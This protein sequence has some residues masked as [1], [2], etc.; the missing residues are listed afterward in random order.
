MRLNGPS[1][2]NYNS[3]PAPE[4]LKG[5]HWG[6]SLASRRLGSTTACSNSCAPGI[7]AV[8]R[9][10][11]TSTAFAASSCFKKEGVCALA[12]SN[13][14]RFLTHLAVS[15]NVAASTE[16]QATHLCRDGY[17]IRTVQELLGHKDVQ[18]C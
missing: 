14:N 18:T 17:D 4:V 5:R 8:V 13:L 11:P 15:E 3:R 10:R 2:L 1:W 6:Y 16:N 9:K 7:T 12:E